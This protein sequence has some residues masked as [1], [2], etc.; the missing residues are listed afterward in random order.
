MKQFSPLKP[1]I[2]AMF[3]LNAAAAGAQTTFTPFLD[4]TE[5]T[6]GFAYFTQDFNVDPSL[7]AESFT[8]FG[9]QS[10]DTIASLTF[11]G[12]TSY[13]G[14]YGGTGTN[15]GWTFTGFNLEA[16][17]YTAFMSMSAANGVTPSS[18]D[19][20]S[21]DFSTTGTGGI[22]IYRTGPGASDGY[23]GEGSFRYAVT[24]VTAVPE[25]ESYAMLLAGLGLMGAIARRRSLKVG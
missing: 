5:P 8:F 4:A 10:F 3:A 20:I 23:F 18:A 17:P 12:T 11:D 25:P 16:N 21:V 14:V 13:Q 9:S 19:Q 6:S 7:S 22:L 15:S 1:L 2:A 24:T